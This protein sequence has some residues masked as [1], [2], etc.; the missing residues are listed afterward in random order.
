MMADSKSKKRREDSAP[1]N[2]QGRGSEISREGFV[3]A[4]DKV[5]LTPKRPKKKDEKKKE[6]DD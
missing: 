3:K 2:K 5:I 6:K 1:I 4:L